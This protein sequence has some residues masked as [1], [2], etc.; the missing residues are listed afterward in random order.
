MWTGNYNEKAQI[1]GPNLGLTAIEL[2]T[3]SDLATIVKSTIGN[4]TVKKKEQNEAVEKKNLLAKNEL[5]QLADF[6]IRMKRHPNYTENIGK[7]LGIVGYVTT[8]LDKVVMRPVIKLATYPDH[9]SIRFTKKGQKG[10]TIFTRIKGSMGWEALIHGATTSP[11]QDTR[12][13]T[14][15]GIPE[16]REYMGRFWNNG[17]EIGQESD[18]IST[19]FKGQ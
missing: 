13:L 7:E 5:Q 12:P 16:N 15:A 11:F 1:H 10:V 19:T 8:A 6:A 17:T 3:I 2:T 18:I 14:Q 9:I 4:V